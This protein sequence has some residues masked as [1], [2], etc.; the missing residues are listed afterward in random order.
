VEIGASWVTLDNL[1]FRGHYWIGGNWAYDQNISV[2]AFAG[3]VIVENCYFHGWTHDGDAGTNNSYVVLAGYG[4]DLA[5]SCVIEDSDGD[6]KSGYG[7]RSWGQVSDSTL[8]DLAWGITSANVGNGNT[9]FNIHDAYDNSGAGAMDALYVYDNV[10]HD[11][12]A[13]ANPLIVNYDADT[14]SPLSGYAWNNVVWNTPGHAPLQVQGISCGSCNSTPPVFLW[15]NTLVATGS[16]ACVILSYTANGNIGELEVLNTQ[17]VT[18]GSTLVTVYPD[19]SFTSLVD[20]GD[21]LM[22]YADAL[23]QGYNVGDDF[24]PANDAG[25]TVGAG[26]NLAS[27][28]AQVQ[29]TLCMD[30]FP[31]CSVSLQS[32]CA[33]RDG[34]ARPDAGAWDI[35]AYEFQ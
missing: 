30:A 9:L 31:S 29:P 24:A 32:L 33:D 35:G 4:N 2:Q 1:E 6:G 12:D 14:S 28:C 22:T 7:S 10:V 3:D 23:T 20:G 15:N 8:H 16:G 34:V 11:L 13:N 5:Q 26:T 27:Q 25:A 17:C 18:S 19:V 21:L